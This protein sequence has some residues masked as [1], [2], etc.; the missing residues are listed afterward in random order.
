[1]NNPLLTLAESPYPLPCPEVA[2]YE[3]LSLASAGAVIP[4]AEIKLARSAARFRSSRPPTTAPLSTL[5]GR[6]SRLPPNIEAGAKARML[7]FVSTLLRRRRLL[8]LAR[9]NILASSDNA[10]FAVA[11]W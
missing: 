3:F 9:V 1:M 10:L 4:E 8:E 7:A 5:N 2:W 6:D 11:D